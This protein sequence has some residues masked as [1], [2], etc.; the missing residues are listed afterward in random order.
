MQF[1][2]QQIAQLLQG[3]IEGDANVCVHSFAKIEEASP[4]DLA[5]LANPKYLP[6]LYTT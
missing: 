1:S 5:F 2:A 6:H 4:N 3:I